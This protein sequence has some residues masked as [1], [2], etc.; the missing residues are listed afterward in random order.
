VIRH[1]KLDRERV[2]L[3]LGEKAAPLDLTGR[4]FVMH[5]TDAALYDAYRT[6]PLYKH[7]PFLISTPRPNA[8]GEKG[9]TYAIYHATNSIATG[10]IGAEVDYPSGGHSKRYLQ[11]W[12]GLEEWVLLGRQVDDVVETF[13]RLAGRPRLVGRDWL[14]YLGSTMLLADQENAQ[15][16]LE[17]WPDLCKQH[18][19]PCSAMHL[20]SGFT[21]DERTGARWVFHMNKKRY[22][23]FKHMVGVF[24]K[25]GMK[26]VPNVKPCKFVARV[27]LVVYLR[28]S[29]P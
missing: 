12:G 16:L 17:G 10:D 26:I 20:S 29:I 15:E 13:S 6:D 9:L 18:D 23:D 25:A 19:V 22:P 2:H 28:V 24:H 27:G 11:D 7:T 14:G 5:A 1:W 8:N 21:A 3:G 4:K